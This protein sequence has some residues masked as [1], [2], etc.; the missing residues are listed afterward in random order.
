[1][2]KENYNDRDLRYAGTLFSITNVTEGLWS[3]HTGLPQ[4]ALPVL[5]IV[6]TAQ[7][8]RNPCDGPYSAAYSK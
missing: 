3:F 4:A 7:S 1:M 8:L 5:M 6:V 2:I